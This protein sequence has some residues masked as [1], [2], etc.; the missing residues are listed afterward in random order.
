MTFTDTGKG[1]KIIGAIL[2]IYGVLTATHKGEFW[3]F[4]VYPMFSKAGQPW[5]RAIVLD[6]TDVPENEIWQ[7]RTLQGLSLDP[8][9]IGE[10]GVDQIDFANF[11]S[12]T[13]NWTITR[14]NA[15]RRMFGEENIGEQR[16]MAS[17]ANG[18]L[19][20]TDSVVVRIEPFLLIT[21][22]SVYTNPHLTESDYFSGE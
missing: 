6:V 9:P 21:A 19:I 11:M 5:T 8:V 2:L 3:P 15:L 17:K 13:D 18:K 10:I 16:W 20:G 12:K 1:M 14:R 4:S 7:P 22:D